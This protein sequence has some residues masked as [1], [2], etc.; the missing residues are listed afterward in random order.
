MSTALII[1]IGVSILTL[2]LF[3]V[4]HWLDGE[5]GHLL[6]MAVISMIPYVNA[7][8]CVVLIIK[9]LLMLIFTDAKV[10]LK[11]RNRK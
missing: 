6:G 2:C 3:V 7:I 10:I 8:L 11:G 9:V 5:A 1:Y 4:D